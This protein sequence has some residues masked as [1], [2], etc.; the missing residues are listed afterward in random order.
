MLWIEICCYIWMF[1]IDVGWIF[2]LY[3]LEFVESFLLRYFGICVGVVIFIVVFVVVGVGVGGFFVMD[4]IVVEFM[5]GI[6]VEGS[7][8]GG[9]VLDGGIVVVFIVGVRV[10]IIEVGGIVVLVVKF[11]FDLRWRFIFN[12][13]V[14]YELFFWIVNFVNLK[15]CILYSWILWM[16]FIDVFINFVFSKW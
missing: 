7:V 6:G 12:F 11:K 10:F 9:I 5:V 14:L 16:F 15:V 4:L 13:L 8:E 1:L 2:Y 3:G